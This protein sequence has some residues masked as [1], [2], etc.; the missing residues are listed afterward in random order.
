MLDNVEKMCYTIDKE[1]EGKPLNQK[2]K[3]HEI[4]CYI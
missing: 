3:N 4:R 1:R 2:G